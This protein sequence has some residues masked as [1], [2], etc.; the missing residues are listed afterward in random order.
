[1]AMFRC[2]RLMRCSSA[3]RTPPY[4]SDTTQGR[5]N[6]A[7]RLF[8]STTAMPRFCSSETSSGL[9]LPPRITPSTCLFLE[10]LAARSQSA[11]V[12]IISS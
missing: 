7:I 12:E 8:T 1:M 4:S 9:A 10:V 3:W 5:S 6:P 11:A 2:P